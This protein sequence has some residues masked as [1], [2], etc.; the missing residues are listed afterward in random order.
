MYKT[1]LI[2]PR[3]PWRSIEAVQIATP[4][5][6]DWFNNRH[7]MGSIGNVSPAEHEAAYDEQPEAQTMSRLTR[8]NEFPIF[9]GRFGPPRSRALHTLIRAR[10][11]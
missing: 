6:I 11:I 2:R 10:G 3:G 1:G 9:P 7:I 4:E 5:C 8:S